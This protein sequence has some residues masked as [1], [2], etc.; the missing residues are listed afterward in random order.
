MS[1]KKMSLKNLTNISIHMILFY[2]IFIKNYNKLNKTNWSK[3]KIYIKIC[4]I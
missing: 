1:L 2:I 4:K 3:L